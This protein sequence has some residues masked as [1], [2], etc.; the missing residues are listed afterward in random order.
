M[1]GK[2]N[3]F[4]NC[5]NTFGR[6]KEMKLCLLFIL[7][8]SSTTLL[9]QPRYDSKKLVENLKESCESMLGAQDDNANHYKNMCLIKGTEK[10]EKDRNVLYDD[11]IR[12]SILLDACTFYVNET[13]NFFWSPNKESAVECISKVAKLTGH[14]EV[15]KNKNLCWD[16]K[17][18]YTA[19]LK[20]GPADQK[21]ITES[22]IDLLS[23]IMG[24]DE[25]DC[26]N[27]PQD[28]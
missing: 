22:L 15:E 8:L 12:L 7:S 28:Q 27:C 19:C 1:R 26:P 11:G 25:K 14:E 13:Y 24:D 6:I 18:D 16:N 9:G 2:L 23:E 10:M 3:L 4:L 21:P 17:I 20:N 5:F